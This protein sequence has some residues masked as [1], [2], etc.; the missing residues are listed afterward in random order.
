M[1]I[2][3]DALQYGDTGVNTYGEGD[4]APDVSPGFSLSRKTL[5]LDTNDNLSDFTVL[6]TPTPGVAPTTASVPEPGPLSLL[7][8]GLTGLLLQTKMKMRTAPSTNL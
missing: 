7:M 3:V 8:L 6:D 4:F 2:L 5:G 1:N